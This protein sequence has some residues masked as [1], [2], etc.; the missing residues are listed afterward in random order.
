MDKINPSSHAPQREL[1][2][3]LKRKLKSLKVKKEKSLNLKLSKKIVA[4]FLMILK[5][6]KI[7]ELFFRV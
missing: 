2:W 4:K 7:K 5:N 3:I 6:K 1:H